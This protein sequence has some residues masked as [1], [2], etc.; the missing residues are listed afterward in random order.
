MKKFFEKYLI[1]G[2][3]SLIIIIQLIFSFNY[4][5]KKSGFFV[6]EIFSYSFANSYDYHH[7]QDYDIF[8]WQNNDYYRD[9]LAVKNNQRFAYLKVYGNQAV[10]THPPFYHAVLHTVS[11]FV[12]NVFT[13]WI[14]LAINLIANLGCLVLIYLIGKKLFKNKYI[15]LIPLILYGFSCGAF[16]SILFIRMYELLTFFILLYTYLII[17]INEKFSKNKLILLF[18]VLFLGF[19]TQYH[20]L[21]YAFFISLFQV[22]FLFIKKEYKKMFVFSGG[23]LITVAGGFFFFKSAIKHLFL[24]GPGKSGLNAL[25]IKGLEKIKTCFTIIDTQLFNNKFKYIFFFIAI[26]FIIGIIMKIIKKDKTDK[27]DMLNVFLIIM[28]STILFFLIV[29]KTAI[30]NAD[31]YF[32]AMYPLFM[33][34]IVYLI[35]QLMN[36]LISNEKIKFIALIIVFIILISTTFVKITPNY[37]YETKKNNYK[38]IFDNKNNNVIYITSKNWKIGNNIEYFLL[39]ENIRCIKEEELN[40]LNTIINGYETKKLLVYIDYNFDTDENKKHFSDI[41][42]EIEK[43][44]FDTGTSKVYLYAKK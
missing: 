33:I 11:S 40:E 37:L 5:L 13:K 16:S 18:I 22:I 1:Y 36:Y 3:L 6:D 28:I 34:I 25:S 10:D 2:L 4:C 31:R 19:M 8:N 43:L 9:I 29:A 44:L 41:N 23:S 17:L 38:E 30:Y 39:S 7:I 12:P 42:Y 32:F 27:C 15:A 20:F 26:L 35:Y 24:Q 21:F 14:G